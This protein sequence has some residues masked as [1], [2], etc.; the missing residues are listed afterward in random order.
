MEGDFLRCCFCCSRYNLWSAGRSR[1]LSLCSSF[2]SSSSSRDSKV[3][4]SSWDVQSALMVSGMV[5]I[6]TGFVVILRWLLPPWLLL[7]LLFPPNHVG[8]KLFPNREDEGLLRRAGPTFCC[9]CW[10]CCLACSSVEDLACRSLCEFMRVRA[11]CS[12]DD[13]WSVVFIGRGEGFIA[14][15]LSSLVHLAAPIGKILSEWNG[16]YKDI[17]ILREWKGA[18]RRRKNKL[19]LSKSDLKWEEK[20][21]KRNKT[22]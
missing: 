20:D 2:I 1:S 10:W 12:L 17:I 14:G 4:S 11:V 5:G 21:K 7:L 13:I 6:G 22:E 18:K 9:C 8:R 15:A 19:S 16:Y 3:L